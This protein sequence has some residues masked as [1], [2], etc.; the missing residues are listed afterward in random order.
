MPIYL[1][2]CSDSIW[3]IVRPAALAKLRRQFD[4]TEAFNYV[5]V[6]LVWVAQ[7]VLECRC[8][9]VET[10]DLRF[11]ALRMVLYIIIV[12]FFVRLQIGFVFC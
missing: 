8:G 11:D 6:E 10:T 1:N 4:C 7:S 3:E 5:N 9:H 2:F 12:V